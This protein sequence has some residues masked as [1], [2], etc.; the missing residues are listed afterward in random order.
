MIYADSS[1]TFSLYAHDGNSAAANR[2]YQAD[3]RRPLIF[4][5]WQELEL[6]NTFRLGVH[7]ARK[8]KLPVRYQPANCLKRIQEDLKDGRLR[9]EEPDWRACARQA[10]R[11]SQQ[12]TET[13][14]VVMLDLWHIACAVE[15]GADTF[16]TFDAEQAEVATACGHFKKVLA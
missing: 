8:Q 5:P 4:T 10:E 6:T 14:G 9:R 13:L 2:I 7:R 3:G 12:H 1:F 16:W 11:L 15:L